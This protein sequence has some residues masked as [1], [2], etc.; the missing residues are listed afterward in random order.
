MSDNTTVVSHIKRLGRTHSLS[1]FCLTQQLFQWSTQHQVTLRVKFI[2]GHPNTMA[3]LLSGKGQVGQSRM[4]LVETGIQTDPLCFYK[5]PSRSICDIS[6]LSTSFVCEPISRQESLANRCSDNQLGKHKG[7]CFSS[8]NN[9]RQSSK[10]SRRD[11]LYHSPNSSILAQPTM[12]SIPSK[13]VGRVTNCTDS[14]QETIKSTKLKCLPFQAREYQTSHVD[15]IKVRFLSEGFSEEVAEMPSKPQRKSSL[16]VH[17]SHFNSFRDWCR[18][19][20]T[21]L[22]SVN[23]QAVADY[24]L[25]MFKTLGRQVATICNHRTALSAAPGGINDFSVGNHPVTTNLINSFWVEFYYH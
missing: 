21:N 7:V 12:V 14:Q 4:D 18:T 2:P 6:Q 15:S 17:Q 3:D 1:L 24:L 19:M 9:H 20:D 11:G 8:H 23:I 10:E 25:Y 13:L 16:S 22:E 5:S